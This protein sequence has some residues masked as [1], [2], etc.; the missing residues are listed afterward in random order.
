MTTITPPC[1]CASRLSP[2][3]ILDSTESLQR[4]DPPPQAGPEKTLKYTVKKM[5]VRTK[6]KQS[7]LKRRQEGL[8][9]YAQ[10]LSAL[11]GTTAN[12]GL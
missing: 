10:V 4:C 5:L 11:G 12:G 7:S 2:P 1:A 9:G 8:Q 3:N 6:S